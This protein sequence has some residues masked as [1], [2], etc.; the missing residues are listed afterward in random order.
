MSSIL[1]S[2]DGDEEDYKVHTEHSKTEDSKRRTLSIGA[3]DITDL[4]ENQHRSLN[5]KSIVSMSYQHDMIRTILA[6]ALFV[7]REWVEKKLKYSN[8]I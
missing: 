5:L 3:Q 6:F 7:A 8:I 1:L 2:G 4:K